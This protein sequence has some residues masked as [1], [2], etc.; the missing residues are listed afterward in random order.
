MTLELATQDEGTMLWTDRGGLDADRALEL[1]RDM[2][3]SWVRLNIYSSG[4]H[5]H[6]WGPY[7]DAIDRARAH[8]L[9]VQVTLTG[10]PRWDAD[11]PDGGVP[12]RDPT[13][14]QFAK[15]AGYCVKHL[16]DRVRR[17]SLWNEPNHPAFLDV[18]EGNAA[19]LY[20][21]LY[22]TAYDAVRYA[23]ADCQILFGELSGREGAQAFLHRA[24]EA[25]PTFASGI[26]IHPYQYLS[27]PLD[28]AAGDNL[29]WGHL[30]E[31]QAQLAT[32]ARLG[33]LRTRSG[34][35]LPIYITEFGYFC[36]GEPRGIPEG[37]RAAYVSSTIRQA[38]RW[39][40]RQYLYYHLVQ[41]PDANWN[42]GIVRP[43]GTP[44]AT[45]EAIQREF[46]GQSL[47]RASRRPRRVAAGCPRRSAGTASGSARSP[48]A[49][50][51]A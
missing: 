42:S 4:L 31:L 36:A 48:G 23:D 26:A 34:K 8:G 16:R 13:P 29:Q 41:A 25:A 15:Y 40:L 22:R 27:N 5:Q 30:P 17:F 51:A 21:R 18:T 33:R 47:C 19:A 3:C 46:R 32:L 28:P 50:S 6:G 49:C 10:Q 12:Y 45:Y 38:R 9:S 11:K 43:D 24:I 44:T 14:E 35:P 2:G 20:G 37:R 1:A 7:D 39:G